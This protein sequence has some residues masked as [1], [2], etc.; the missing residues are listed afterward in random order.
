MKR[1]QLNPNDY[2]LRRPYRSEA[3]KMQTLA[4]LG[5]AAR[6]CMKHGFEGPRV[7]NAIRAG[8]DGKGRDRLNPPRGLAVRALALVTGH[9]RVSWDHIRFSVDALNSAMHMAG[10]NP[11]AGEPAIEK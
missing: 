7:L 2:P 10:L 11:I 3:E 4:T 1:P 5:K 8:S 9:P 6:L